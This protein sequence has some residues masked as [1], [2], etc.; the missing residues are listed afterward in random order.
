MTKLHTVQD[1]VKTPDNLSAKQIIGIVKRLLAIG[2]EDAVDSLQCQH[3]P[4]AEVAAAFVVKGVSM[5][6]GEKGAGQ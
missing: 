6:T 3:A 1:K 4:E 2:V 5:V